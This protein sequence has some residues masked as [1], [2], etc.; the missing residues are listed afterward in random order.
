MVIEFY[1]D[2]TGTIRWQGCAM[3]ISPDRTGWSSELYTKEQR[4]WK[5]ERERDMV[6]A[7]K[8]ISFVE[9]FSIKLSYFNKRI[10]EGTSTMS[11]KTQQWFKDHYLDGVSGIGR[12]CQILQDND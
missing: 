5:K 3:F 6:F 4:K 9:K 7:E 11:K 12:G 8:I 1:S 10:D 2:D